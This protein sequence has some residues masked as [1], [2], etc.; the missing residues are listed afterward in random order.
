MTTTIGSLDLNAF[1]DLYS[2][3]NQY[4]WFESNS[5]ATYGA[6]AHVTLVPDTTF[7]NNPTGQNILMNTDGFSI[8]NG[9]LPMMTLDNDSLDFNIVDT[10]A[11]TYTTTATFTATSAQIGQSGGA[12]SIIDANGQR[13]YGGSDGTKRLANIGYGETGGQGGATNSSFYT[14]GVRKGDTASNYDPTATYSLG[15]LCVYDGVLYICVQAITTPEAWDS[16]KWKVA[17]GSYSMAEGLNV[18]AS[19]AISHAEGQLTTASGAMSHAEGQLTTASGNLSHAEGIQTTASASTSHAEGQLTT[20][21]GNAS[22]AEGLQ[23]TA[24]ASMSHAEGAQTTANGNFSHAEGYGTIASGSMSHAQ[25]S[26]T[27]ATEADQTVI[28]K[29]NSAT[30]S[31]SGTDDDPYVY[32][33]VGNYAFIIGNGTLNTTNHRS[34][35]FTVDWNGNVVAKGNVT[36]GSGNKLSDVADAS[37]LTSGTLPVA[38][39]PVL[40][41]K[42]STTSSAQTLNYNSGKTVTI[43]IPTQS[44]YE[45]LGVI[46]VNTNHAYA[47][48]IGAFTS[49]ATNNTA[50]VAV[51]NRNTSASGNFTDLTVTVYC[52]WVRTN[53]Y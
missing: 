22:H 38:R 21:S 31:G 19:G 1:S 33:N 40:F 4:F 8:R 2:D 52:L 51:T 7:I 23:T 20:A 10:T 26:F 37:K 25:N 44:G 32:T 6:G 17:I 12:H 43:T 5:S 53:I 50:S 13:F 3:S 11:G 24:S 39:L 28:G 15:S 29:Y 34:N 35:A 49:N 41:K 14:F 47:T 27:V 16:T 18:V 30:V 9:L 42:T 46:G 45:L 48:S 36:N